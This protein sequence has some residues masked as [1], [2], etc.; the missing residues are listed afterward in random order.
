MI[1]RSK[2]APAIRS[3][4]PFAWA[5][6]ISS[7]RRS[8]RGGRCP[9]PITRSA[10]PP[11]TCSTS[12]DI[13]AAA[14]LTRNLAFPHQADHRN[15]QLA[16]LAGASNSFH[17]V[18]SS[19]PRHAGKGVNGGAGRPLIKDVKGVKKLGHWGVE[20]QRKC[21]SIRLRCYQMTTL[22]KSPG[23]VELGDLRHPGTS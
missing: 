6:A 5:G 19:A 17:P 9:R 4:R 21:H 8:P 23:I 11:W 13:K 3:T 22:R 2:K 20:V 15:V 14:S 7:C 18:A 12:P 16:P 1:G 10:A